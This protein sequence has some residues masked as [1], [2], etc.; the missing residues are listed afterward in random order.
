MKPGLIVIDAHYLCHRAFH[1]HGYLSWQGSPTGVAFGFLKS[2]QSF[3]D[4]LSTNRIMFCFEGKNL[5]RRQIYALYK[6]RNLTMNAY[7]KQARQNL[8]K[9][10]DRLRDIYLPEAG[11]RNVCC[12]EGYE[13]DDLM[14]AI[15]FNNPDTNVY[16]VTADSDMYQCLRPNVSIWSPQKV[17]LL[18]IDWFEKE[19]KM[20]PQKWAYVKALAGCKGDNVRGIERIGEKTALRLVRHDLPES[21][22]AWDAA[23]S[24]MGRAI[25]RRNLRLVRL[26]FEGCPTPTW[27]PDHVTLKTW[28]KVCERIGMKTLAGRPPI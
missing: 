9:Q 12:E 24:R 27:Q 19:Y 26:P 16:L 22:S 13:S 7:E 3:I 5:K 2:I 18:T 8:S 6:N 1:A 4:D 25:F 10:I 11:Y 21:H 14:A 23:R 17:R 28:T 15:A 20:P